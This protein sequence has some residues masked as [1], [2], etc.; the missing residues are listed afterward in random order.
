MI[1][2]GWLNRMVF[3][4]REFNRVATSSSVEGKAKPYQIKQLLSLVEKYNLWMRAEGK[5]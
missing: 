3:V 5:P 1:L 4:S 2:F